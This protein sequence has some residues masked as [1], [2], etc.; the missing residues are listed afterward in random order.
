LNDV[1][2]KDLYDFMPTEFSEISRR[3]IKIINEGIENVPSFQLKYY[4][5]DGTLIDIDATAIPIT[6][7]GVKSILVMANDITDKIN[8]QRKLI[9]T[10]ERFSLMFNNHSAIMMLV[11]SETGDINN[12]NESAVKFYGYSKQDLLSMKISN[13]NTLPPENV[14]SLM[15]KATSKGSN[16][17]I[18]KHRLANDGIRDVEVYA[19]PINY[20]GRNF[21][22][23]IIH[24]ITER[25]KA[26]R[27]L[28]E[29]EE[30]LTKAQKVANIG[31]YVLNIKDGSWVCSKQMDAILGINQSHKRIIDTWIQGIHPDDRE[32]M[33]TYFRENVLQKHRQFDKEYRIIRFNDQAL[34]WV[35][36][37][38]D[39]RLDEDGNVLEMFGTI[40][41]VTDRIMAEFDLLKTQFSI[42]KAKDM[43]YWIMND[44]K[45]AYVNEAA[46]KCTG[47]TKLELQSMVI[48]DVDPTFPR[49]TWEEHW[50]ESRLL[51][52]KTIETIHQTKDGSQF[53]VE[54]TIDFMNYGGI[55]YHCS[56]ARDITERKKVEYE[57]RESEIRYK[58]I[59]EFSPYSLMV[60]QNEKIIYANNASIELLGANSPDELV[61][62]SIWDII[63]E[64]YKDII[65]NNISKS[66]K[67]ASPATSI[68]HKF[69]KRNGQS[70]DVETVAVPF[71]TQGIFSTLFITRFIGD[72]KEKN[73]RLRKLQR[74]V[75]QSSAAIMIS[76]R[77]GKID[78]V[79]PKFFEIT[80]YT[81][82]E[83][84]A[85]TTNLLKSGYHDKLFYE[86][87]WRTIL[88]GN[89]WRGEIRNKKKSGEL[90]WE[91]DSISS[92]KNDSGEI[93][94][95][96]AIKEDITVSKKIQED[97]LLAKEEAEEANKVKSSLLAN[98]SHEFR[99]P[100]NGILGFTQL[101]KDIVADEEILLMIQKIEKSGKRLMSTLNA[102]LSLTEL[103]T[104]DFIVQ[105][106]EVDL[107]YF[108]SEIKTMHERGARERNLQLELD[109]CVPGLNTIIDESLL[110]KIV[111]GIC[112]NAIKYTSQGSV[113]IQL[114]KPV[115]KDGIEFGQINIID[116]GIGIKKENQEIIFK[117][118]RQLSEGIR[119][120]F[121]GLGLGLTLAKRMARLIDAEIIVES[122]YGK[123]STFS[124]LF[125]IKTSTTDKYTQ[126]LEFIKKSYFTKLDETTP[127]EVL[128]I[129]LV[130]DN[131]LNIEVV[132]RF[133][134]KMGN[135]KEARDGKNALK[136]AAEENFDLLLIDINLGA[137]IDGT[138]VLRQLRML[139]KY[140]NTPSVALTGYASETNKRDFLAKGF[141]GYLAKPFEKKVL[142]NL[143]KEL[144]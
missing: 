127:G 28:K 43:V 38:G 86:N 111:S 48:F 8:A 129:L 83:A 46:C 18:F 65:G 131:P 98:M 76:N 10:E 74:A 24:D 117:E 2:G 17:F 67:F 53:P 4:C 12:V 20:E 23:S 19:C 91:Y 113:T 58:T 36:G 81:Y 13:L 104:E 39:L 106:N 34:R 89:E 62:I 103:E 132:Q 75:E 16:Y 57:L 94:H 30:L 21:L 133:L 109:L 59:L 120:D 31:H 15:K 79:N 97:I 115:I 119:R 118:F 61:G 88:C 123:G 122:E 138:E 121:E 114:A 50:K 6:Y 105:E 11:D 70:I 87:L 37:L 71:T 125:P 95:F 49:H 56:Y 126:D 96:L 90:Y 35:H 140:K 73:E 78:Y 14:Y 64:D 27:L 144:V 54:V 136:I 135:V 60:Q 84:T 139:D 3:R 66:H 141:T 7:D 33:V 112:D 52:S 72:L 77:D 44:G 116:T 41:D 42:D 68:E 63:P 69:R 47:Y 40:Q 142:I 51:G 92:I 93:T 1:I 128:K 101:L 102:V 85:T 45:I 29:N 100:L 130:E 99:T 9:E 55:E 107:I 143:L 82:E 108:C 110:S 22:F 5:L 134:S 124:I 26:E 32:M 25:E 80:G 137:G